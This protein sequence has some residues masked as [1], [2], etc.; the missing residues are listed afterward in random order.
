MIGFIW[1]TRT[2]RLA[3]LIWAT[4]V[5]VQEAV[6]EA[7]L[8]TDVVESIGEQRIEPL[9]IGCRTSHKADNGSHIVRH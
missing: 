8:V 9:D 4:S 2:T 7:G 1:P 6:K 5:V 3:H